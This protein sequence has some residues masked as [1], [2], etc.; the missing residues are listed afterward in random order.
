MTYRL[1]LRVP[2]AKGT[3]RFHT[4]NGD[5]NPNTAIEYA[6]DKV[7]ECIELIVMYRAKNIRSFKF[8]P[9]NLWFFI[10][11]GGQPNIEKP[12]QIGQFQVPLNGEEPKIV[13]EWR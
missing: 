10:I 6:L 4:I 11:K 8:L 2:V 13:M 7:Q 9:P 12:R 5:I 3:G 1:V